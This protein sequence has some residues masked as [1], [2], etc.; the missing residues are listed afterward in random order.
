MRC[1]GDSV[2]AWELGFQSI[3]VTI[4]Q[5]A[6]KENSGKWQQQG[7]SKPSD[8]LDESLR[9]VDPLRRQSIR[10]Q[11]DAEAKNLNARGIR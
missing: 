11:A 2:L 6:S 4:N 1:V 8:Q 10:G 9:R 5:R 7:S 3:K